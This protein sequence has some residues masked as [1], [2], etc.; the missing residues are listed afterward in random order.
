MKISRLISLL[1]LSTVYLAANGPGVGVASAATYFID[2]SAAQQG[3]GSQASPYKT[4]T[5]ISFQPGNSYLQKAGTNFNGQ[6]TIYQAAGTVAL[7]IVIGHYGSGGLPKVVSLFI[8]ASSYVTVQNFSISG[9]VVINDDTTNHH[10][11]I[12]NNTVANPAAAGIFVGGS[13]GNNTITGNTITGVGGAGITVGTAKLGGMGG[14]GTNLALNT[15]GDSGSH[16]IEY[17]ASYGTIQYN[18]IFGSGR[19]VGGSSGIHTYAGGYNGQP[20]ADK[21]HHNTITGNVV[22]DTHDTQ[23]D[24]NGIQ[25]D[26][27]TRNNTVW[28]NLVF[29]NDGEGVSLY[30][31][32]SNQIEKNVFFNNGLDRNISHSLAGNII[33]DAPPLGVRVA[34]DLT[35]QGN[36]IK[37]NTAIVSAVGANR[38]LGRGPFGFEVTPDTG[39]NHYGGNRLLVADLLDTLMRYYHT[40]SPQS[41]PANGNSASTWNAGAGIPAKIV[42]D[43]SDVFGSVPITHITD[44]GL[45]DF[46]IPAEHAVSF[47]VNGQ[48]ESLYGWSE[49]VGLFS[50]TPV[51]A[52]Y[53]RFESAP[54]FAKDQLNKLNLTLSYSSGSGPVQHTLPATGAGSK[55]PRASTIVQRDNAS[56]AKLVSA[57][58]DGF[59]AS[60]YANLPSGA[61]PFTIEAF[62]NLASAGAGGTFRTIAA[63]GATSPSTY[64]A[65]HLVVTGEGSS[66][67]PRRLIF[68][69]SDNGQGAGGSYDTLNSGFTLQPGVDYY[70]AVAFN[71]TDTSSAGTTFYFK[72]LTNNGP[73]QTSKKTHS[74]TSVF[75]PYASFTVGKGWPGNSWD[76]L[77][78]EVRVSN[79]G[80]P[81]PH[82]LLINQPP[83]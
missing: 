53:Y 45:V 64:F 71:P 56:A 41:Y 68:Q 82:Q 42:H 10:I 18:V 30:G 23:G 66:Q 74:R 21:S 62:V 12:A 37:N 11:T 32:D 72:D 73:L 13:G 19:T 39:A 60:D 2:P 17:V 81:L 67:G 22:Y 14:Y 29:S 77:I 5:G 20:L 50:P 8:V 79:R 70:V 24:G 58:G 27:A 57:N 16:G 49:T 26:R 31:S 55:F 44:T 9:G 83:D 78:D 51:P 7:P 1:I 76:G 69:F 59:S 36:V 75:N 52:V 38:G 61:T 25:L 63:H 28:N 4:W 15:I 3:S 34:G 47:I 43:S 6:L 65:W 46:F 54:G 40:W 33:V 35:T 48:F 80:R